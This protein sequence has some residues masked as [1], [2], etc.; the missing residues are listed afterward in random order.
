MEHLDPVNSTVTY[1]VCTNKCVQTDASDFHRTAIYN[2]T[3]AMCKGRQQ[4]RTMPI[5]AETGIL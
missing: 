2:T 4:H 5:A 3:A 1:A